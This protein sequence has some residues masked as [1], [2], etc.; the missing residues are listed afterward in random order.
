[1]KYEFDINKSKLDYMGVI[2][3]RREIPQVSKKIYKGVLDIILNQ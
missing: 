2:L 1:M 3:V